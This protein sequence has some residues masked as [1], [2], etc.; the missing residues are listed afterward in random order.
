[1]PESNVEPEADAVEDADS[2][3]ETASPPAESKPDLKGSPEPTGNAVDNDGNYAGREE[4]RN[5]AKT[6]KASTPRRNGSRTLRIT[7]RASGELERDKYRVNQI[8]DYMRD[9]KGRDK[10]LLMVQSGSHIVTLAFPDEPCSITDRLMKEL[11]TRFRVDAEVI[12]S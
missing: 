3:P 8:C 11:D 5:Q 1:M 4:K 7:F 6:T 9:P 12:A 2:G 10:F